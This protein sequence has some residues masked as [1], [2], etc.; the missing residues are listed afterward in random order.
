M[1]PVVA[2]GRVAALHGAPESVLVHAR[3]AVGNPD[4]QG[5]VILAHG[6]LHPWFVA[7]R[8]SR[9]DPKRDWYVWRDPKPDGSPPNNWLSLFGGG[10][11]EFD[12]RT[13][14]SY[15]HTFLREQPDL[16]WLTLDYLAEVSMSILARQ[17]ERD[18]S[19]GYARDFL[20][21]IRSLTPTWKSGRKLRGKGFQEVPPGDRLVVLTPG[22]GGIGAPS[23]PASG[24]RQLGYSSIV[25]GWFCP[26]RSP[27]ASVSATHSSRDGVH[28]R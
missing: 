19:L 5:V 27:T 12:A 2:L 20:D 1:V 18:P 9:D 4:E 15:L 24:T 13:G 14:Q 3:P 21:V 10:A 25:P 26:R 8:S 16:D 11:W 17:R 7:S 6:H 23:G 22:G 28:V